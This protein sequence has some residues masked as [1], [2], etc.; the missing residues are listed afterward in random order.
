MSDFAKAMPLLIFNMGSE[1]LYIISARLEAQRIPSQ[2]CVKGMYSLGHIHCYDH[3]DSVGRS[4]SINAQKA[5]PRWAF[6][7]TQRAEFFRCASAVWPLGAFVDYAT[8]CQ[9]Y[10]QTLWS[11]AHGLQI[12]NATLLIGRRIA[13]SDR[14]AFGRYSKTCRYRWCLWIDHWDESAHAA[15]ALCM[16]CIDSYLIDCDRRIRLCV[17]HLSSQ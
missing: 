12:P 2:K 17:Q 14:N 15:G 8:E 4:H 1:M 13:A 10:G 7:N 6:P 9:Q 5:I 11:D 3:F 16:Q